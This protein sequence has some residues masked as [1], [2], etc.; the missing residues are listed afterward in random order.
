MDQEL[1]KSRTENHLPPPNLIL[2]NLP[3]ENNMLKAE[4]VR[5]SKKFIRRTA[6]AATL[7]GDIIQSRYNM[8]G[9]PLWSH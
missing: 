3:L 9:D 1:F 6:M 8:P 7:K 2:T 4:R 5:P